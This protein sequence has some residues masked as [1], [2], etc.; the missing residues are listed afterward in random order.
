VWVSCSNKLLLV[1][2][3]WLVHWIQHAGTQVIITLK[4]STDVGADTDRN[5]WPRRSGLPRPSV[6]PQEARQ[7]RL[8]NARSRRRH[9]GRKS[10]AAVLAS[11]FGPVRGT[12]ETT[13]TLVGRSMPCTFLCRGWSLTARSTDFHVPACQTLCAATAELLHRLRCLGNFCVT[14]T[15]LGPMASH[16]MESTNRLLTAGGIQNPSVR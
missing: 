12:N 3:R 7:I 10:N 16:T 9:Q 8:E 13:P 14:L 15:S 6:L 11:H 2:S 5:L 4:P 1:A